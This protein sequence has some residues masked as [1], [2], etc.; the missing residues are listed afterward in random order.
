MKT[1]LSRNLQQVSLLIHFISEDTYRQLSADIAF[2]I[3]QAP[4]TLDKYTTRTFRHVKY[5]GSSTETNKLKFP[6]ANVLKGDIIWPKQVHRNH[7]H[8]AN[9]FSLIKI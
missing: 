7:H 2:T 8:M 1:I 9:M 5:V 6:Q 4:A 3:R